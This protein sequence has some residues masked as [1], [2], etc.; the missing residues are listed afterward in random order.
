MRI[1]ITKNR[2]RSIRE[3]QFSELSN[4]EIGPL[5][6]TI[7]AKK[8]EG[9]KAESIEMGIDVTQEF[10]THFSAGIRA[11]G[12]EH[13][14]RFAP[15]SLWI[16]TINAARRRKNEKRNAALSSQFE[17][18]L[19]SGYVDLL[20]S[21]RIRNGRT[22]PSLGRKVNDAVVRRSDFAKCPQV[23]DIGLHQSKTRISRGR[24]K[25]G[26][27][28]SCGLKGVK[29]VGDCNTGAVGKKCFD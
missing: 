29:I 9:E 22:H 1:S 17:H 18:V 11:D 13:G 24:K 20:T 26:A 14:V 4:G 28:V 5:P 19:S 7:N 16:D 2:N 25:I 12:K 21:D 3:H 15:R 8:P 10:T 23:A 27:L 6:G